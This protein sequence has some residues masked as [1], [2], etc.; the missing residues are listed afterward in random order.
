M[1]ASILMGLVAGQRAMT[2]LAAVAAAAARGELRQEGAAGRLLGHPLV[3]AGALAL[4]AAEMGG[5]KLKSAPDRI[6]L[7]GLA[8]R[9]ATATVA[10]AALA[11]RGE[12][13]MAAALAVATALGASWLGWRARLAAIERHGR[14]P[15]GFAEDALALGSAVAIIRAA[16]R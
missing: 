1:L 6:V 7:P 12:R 14:V 4:A 15:T 11:P 8:A 3:A 2:P 5:D 13:R 10:G 9:V 16:S